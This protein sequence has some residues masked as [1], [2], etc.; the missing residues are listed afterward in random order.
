[1]DRYVNHIKQIG[2]SLKHK[3]LNSSIRFGCID[4]F[5][6]KVIKLLEI[7]YWNKF[8]LYS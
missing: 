1:M 2:N 8:I 7:Y 5:N 6:C 3:W 4:Y